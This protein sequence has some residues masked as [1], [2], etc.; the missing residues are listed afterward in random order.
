M[1]DI[2]PLLILFLISLNVPSLYAQ[3][4][5][6]PPPNGILLSKNIF[7]DKTEISNLHWM[8]YLYYLRKD[9]ALENY[10]KALPDTNVW[11]PSG[12]TIRSINYLRHPSYRDFPVV[13]I[14]QQQ[15][16][17][18]CHWRSAVVNNQVKNDSSRK[19]MEY[20]FRLPTEE[21][22]MQ[23]AAGKLDIMDYPF[24]YEKILGKSALKK[25]QAKKYFKKVTL[26]VDYKTF[27]RDLDAFVNGENEISFNVIK[28]FNEY[29]QYGDYAPAFQYDARTPANSLGLHHMIGNVAEMVIEKNI[30][31]GGSWYHHLY[32]SEIAYRIYYVNPQP[33]LGFR[34]I[35]EV[36]LID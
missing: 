27:K 22:W 18:Y 6:P 28:S 3:Q 23:A 16:V 2:H 1:K 15:A 14:S 21:E 32:E 30:S 12:D 13:G 33:W 36:T 31:K 17:N 24:G 7:I 4:E 29:F 8:E 20:H 35:C 25:N 10:Q 34:C 5:I 11:L 19:S 9:S 26:E